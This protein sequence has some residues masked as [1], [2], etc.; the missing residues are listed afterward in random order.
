MS[1]KTNFK[2]MYT[3]V[4]RVL[5]DDEIKF[6]IIDKD[7]FKWNEASTPKGALLGGL[8]CGLQLRDIEIPMFVKDFGDVL[9]RAGGA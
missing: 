4:K 2:Y 1:D 8:A 9:A 5:D 7:G 6:E 3:L